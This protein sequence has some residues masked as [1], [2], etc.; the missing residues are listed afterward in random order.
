[1]GEVVTLVAAQVV[2]CPVVYS[3]ARPDNQQKSSRLLVKAVR[4]VGKSVE[5]LVP[6]KAR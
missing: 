6:S 2:Q 5:L 4:I 1:M 3:G